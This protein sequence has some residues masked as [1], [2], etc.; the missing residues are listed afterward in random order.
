MKLKEHDGKV[1]FDMDGKDEDLFFLSNGRYISPGLVQRVGPQGIFPCIGAG[2][3]P[4]A[5]L[6]RLQGHLY[7]ARAPREV[8]VSRRARWARGLSVALG[9]ATAKKLNND[10]GTVYVLMGDGEQQGR[11]GLGSRYFRYH[12]TR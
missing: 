11:P 3:F 4:Q 6:S 7:H 12:T 8:S 10:K 2:Y 9:A 5:E 1:V